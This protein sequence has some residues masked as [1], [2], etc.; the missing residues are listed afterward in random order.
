MYVVLVM[1]ELAAEI[2]THHFSGVGYG[3]GLSKDPRFELSIMKRRK[4]SKVDLV[5]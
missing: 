4:Y 1:E 3:S 5:G 2:V